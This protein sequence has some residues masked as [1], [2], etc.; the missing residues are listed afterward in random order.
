MKKIIITSMLLM[1][2][3]S[4]GAAAISD[5]AYIMND[6]AMKMTIKLM[7]L[8][9]GKV[10][11]DGMGS[12]GD[13]KNCRIGDMGAFSGNTLVLGGLCSVPIAPTADGFQI[14]S[15]PPCLQCDH[16]GYIQGT[17]KRAAQ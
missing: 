10:F 17:Y 9:D 2:A 15:T 8:P 1:G 12:S 16:G 5:G 4:A 7:T 3:A 11:V 13:G 14:S 6:G